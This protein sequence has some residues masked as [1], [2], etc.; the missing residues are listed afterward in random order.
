MQLAI[1]PLTF[2]PA[3]VRPSVDSLPMVLAIFPLTF[4]PVT[5][6]PSLDSLPMLFVMFPLTFILGTAR[7]F[8]VLQHFFE[9][10]MPKEVVPGTHRN[11]YSLDIHVHTM[12]FLDVY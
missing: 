7:P 1:C 9:S 10:T 2:I 3:S 11:E 5:A 6:R 12:V 4:I 8:V